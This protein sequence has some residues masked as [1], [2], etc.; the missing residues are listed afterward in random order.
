MVQ[1]RKSLHELEKKNLEVVDVWTKYE[2]DE[3]EKKVLSKK[4]A[5]E[6]QNKQRLEDEKKAVSSNFKAKID[7]AVSQINLLASH[8][9]NGYQHRNI[10]C[11]KYLNFA[12]KMR[13]FY[14]VETGELINE[15]T[16]T[17]EDYQHK[18]NFKKKK[19]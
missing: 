3:D 14:C 7:N 13:E 17:R 12:R 16:F 8:I 10:E 4:L 5:G 9:A 11:F 19:G 18:L 1:R 6:N 2:F 15:E